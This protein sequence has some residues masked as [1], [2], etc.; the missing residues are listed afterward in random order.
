M[1]LNRLG[2]R[3]CNRCYMKKFIVAFLLCVCAKSLFATPVVVKYIIDGDTFVGDV[4]LKDKNIVRS[5]K[6]RLRN[7]DTPEIHGQCDSEI[8]L[9]NRAKQRLAELIPVDSTIEIKNIKNDKYAG[10][11]DANVFDSRGRDVGSILVREKIGRAYS[12]GKRLSWCG[13]KK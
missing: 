11:I 10:R 9:A 3:K 7:V 4:V 5:V 12:G 2:L 13:N 8:A 1:E 6:I